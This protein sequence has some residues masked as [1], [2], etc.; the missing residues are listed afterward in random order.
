MSLAAS[1]TLNGHVYDKRFA[2]QNLSVYAVA[3]LADAAAKLLTIS[4]QKTKSGVVRSMID[5]SQTVDTQ[6][7][8]GGKPAPVTN[9]SY[10]VLVQAPGQLSTAALAQCEDDL[11]DF[12]A[13]SGVLAKILNQE[14]A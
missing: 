10:C 14:G 9:R 4:Y 6:D 13:T 8:E 1:Y 2:A 11:V 7:I 5:V 3:G 12:L